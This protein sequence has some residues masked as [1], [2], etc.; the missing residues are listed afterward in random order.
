MGKETDRVVGFVEAHAS[1]QLQF[2][3]ELCDENSFTYNKKGTDL[4][5]AKVLSRL[6][7]ILPATTTFEQ[8]SVGDHHVLRNQPG[9][10]AVYLL[11]HMDTVFPPDHPFQKCCLNGDLLSGPGTA[12][13]KGGLAVIVYALQALHAAGLAERLTLALILTADEEVGSP[14]ARSLFLQEATRARACLGAECAGTNGEV[15]VSRN[16][17]LGAVVR[18]L[19]QDR[20]V[21]KSESGKSSATLEL[22]HKVIAL[23]ALNGSVA[24]SSVN[25]GKIEGGLGPA[26]VAREA[27]CLVDVRWTKDAAGDE[28]LQKLKGVIAEQIQ[29]GCRTEFT[30]VNSRPA[31][32]EHEGNRRL[33]ALVKEVAAGLG[34]EIDS[35]HR[36]GSSDANFFGSV[37]VPTLDGLGPIGDRDHTSEEFIRVP[38]LRERTALLAMLLTEIIHDPRTQTEIS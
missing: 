31:M 35:E 4:V 13:M 23:E 5:A 18:C 25:V 36:N 17:K 9:V 32:P 8:A 33:F 20:H 1:E 15:V 7:G 29:E 27:S 3:I 6:E 14:T 37:G 38:S 28:L 24:E 19:G 12:D 11:G 26:T 16:G 30:V 21:G 2:L 22:A 34:Q 10:P